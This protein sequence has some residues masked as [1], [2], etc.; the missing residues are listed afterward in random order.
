[1]PFQ[2]LL[3]PPTWRIFHVVSVFG[4]EAT[5]SAQSW[6]HKPDKI[7]G[8]AKNWSLIDIDI[9]LGN[10]YGHVPSNEPDG[11]CYCNV[12]NVEVKLMRM[13]HTF[14]DKA[15]MKAAEYRLFTLNDWKCKNHQQNHK[16][17][18]NT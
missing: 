11:D 7:V 13:P 14:I 9:I 18:A 1:M 17:N 2:L 6:C 3:K 10:V 4:H 8:V 12:K 5:Q 16:S 15:T